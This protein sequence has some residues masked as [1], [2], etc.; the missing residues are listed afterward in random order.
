[1]NEQG[2]SS[3]GILSVDEIG[4]AEINIMQRGIEEV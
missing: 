2:E 4:D 3:E 1:M